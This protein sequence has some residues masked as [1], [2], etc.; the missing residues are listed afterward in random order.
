MFDTIARVNELASERKVSM[1]E[2]AAACGLNRTTFCMSARRGGQLKVETIEKVCDALQ[3]PL[4]DFF[5]TDD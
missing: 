3:I 1:T 5:T 2:L 4:R